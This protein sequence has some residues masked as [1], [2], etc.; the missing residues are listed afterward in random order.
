MAS[1]FHCS[2]EMLPEMRTRRT[3]KI[4]S[5]EEWM[6][7]KYSFVIVQNVNSN[8]TSVCLIFLRTRDNVPHM[9]NSMPIFL[10]RKCPIKLRFGG[11][12]T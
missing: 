4:N 8:A 6:Q 7:G 5:T 3:K 9:P 2:F 11:K 12:V 10:D 1:Q